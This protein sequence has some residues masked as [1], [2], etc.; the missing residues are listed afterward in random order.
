MS[1]NLVNHSPDAEPEVASKFYNTMEIFVAE[2]FLFLAYF[3]R[4]IPR[5]KLLG[6]KI[7]RLSGLLLHHVPSDLMPAEQAVQVNSEW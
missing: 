7:R 5:V 2:L 6:Q 4:P 3:L 1:S